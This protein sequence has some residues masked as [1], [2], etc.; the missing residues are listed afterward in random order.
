MAFIPDE[1]FDRRSE[2][3]WPALGLYC[4][5]CK[6]RSRKTGS[7]DCPNIKTAAELSMDRSYVRRLRG[8]LAEAGWIKSEGDIITPLVGDFSATAS[9]EKREAEAP[10]RGQ[11]VPE[12]GTNSPLSGD[13]QS[14]KAGQIVP[15]P[16]TNSPQALSGTCISITQEREEP[17]QD[18]SPLPALTDLANARSGDESKTEEVEK[19][20]KPKRKNPAVE[21]WFGLFVE[22]YEAKYGCPYQSAEKDFIQLRRMLEQ[23]AKS[24]EQWLNEARWLKA[25]DN[26]FASELGNHTLADLSARF[27]AFFRNVLDKYNKPVVPAGVVPAVIPR[28]APIVESNNARKRRETFERVGIPDE[29]NPFSIMNRNLARMANNGQNESTPARTSPRRVSP[30]YAALAESFGFSNPSDGAHGDPDGNQ[31]RQGLAR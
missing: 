27:G 4:Y 14:P 18:T 13:N 24:G 15:E 12:V 6:K 16:G 21:P 20:K 22:R 5:Y 25:T 17:A 29:L 23:G 30:A 19:P 28:S 11:I 2:V 26:Y 8:E 31:G 7:Y 3:S 10:R 1:V 9:K